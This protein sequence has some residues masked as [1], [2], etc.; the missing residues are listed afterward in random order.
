MSS[1][2]SVSNRRISFT[3]SAGVHLHA[4][5]RALRHP[6][7]LILYYPPCGLTRFNEH[8]PDTNGC[9]TLG[10]GVR[11]G[12]AGGTGSTPSDVHIAAR[13]STRLLGSGRPR[14]AE[15]HQFYW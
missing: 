5:L 8:M 13:R 6:I 12:S 1:Q 7:A 15:R 14:L 4:L 3:S 11:Y 10:D 9:G 2:R